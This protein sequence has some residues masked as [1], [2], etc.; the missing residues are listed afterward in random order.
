M[1]LTSRF[2]RGAEAQGDLSRNLSRDNL[3]RD[4][5]N[6]NESWQGREIGRSL[7]V[8][9]GPARPAA[10]EI[11][12]ESRGVAPQGGGEGF[13]PWNCRARE[14]YRG[15]DIDRCHVCYAYVNGTDIDRCP[16]SC[17]GPG[18]AERLAKE[19]GHA[20]CDSFP[21]LHP[22]MHLSI[23]SFR[24]LEVCHRRCAMAGVSF[25]ML[26]LGLFVCQRHA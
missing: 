14:R 20:S 15:L 6:A 26:S 21:A 3:S 25:S 23:Y 24:R 2:G 8:P 17:Y 13:G 1:H 5:R 10:P 7:R 12:G 9:L 22:S 11:A 16:I 4:L 18:A 19:K